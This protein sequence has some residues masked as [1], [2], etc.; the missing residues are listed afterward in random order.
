M[1]IPKNKNYIRRLAVVSVMTAIAVICSLTFPMGLTF[2]IGDTIK[3]SPVFII[4]GLVGNIYG[5]KE[6]A[7]VSSLSD[8]I[9]GFAF[10]SISPLITLVKLLTGICFGL[11]LKNSRSIIRIVLCVLTTEIIGSFLLISAILIFRYGAPIFP[12]MYLRAIQTVI[13]IVIEIICLWFLMRVFNLPQKLKKIT[14]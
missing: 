6:A 4:I 14:G 5:W 1:E 3:L 7:L 10:G 11:F 2:R 13:L 12:T 8:L 9:Q